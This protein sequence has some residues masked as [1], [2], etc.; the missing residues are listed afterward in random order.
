[1][2]TC[3]KEATLAL[4]LHG[5]KGRE[6]HAKADHELQPHHES[7]RKSGSE[8]HLMLCFAG[9]QGGFGS[10]HHF[11]LAEDQGGLGSMHSSFMP[12][13]V[14]AFSTSFQ[15]RCIRTPQNHKSNPPGTHAI[16]AG[17]LA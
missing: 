9:G 8:H 11:N 2:Q 15:S 3:C 4:D 7:R 6:A 17:Q 5:R 16:A 1:M 10:T 13:F 12:D 14:K